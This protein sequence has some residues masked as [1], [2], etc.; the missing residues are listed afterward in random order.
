MPQLADSEN[1]DLPQNSY[2]HDLLATII[3]SSTSTISVAVNIRIP[4]TLRKSGACASSG[5][6]ALL[7]THM[8]SLGMRLDSRLLLSPAPAYPRGAVRALY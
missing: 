8:K 6:Q 4:R 1:E 5:Y 2:T 3:H 7:S